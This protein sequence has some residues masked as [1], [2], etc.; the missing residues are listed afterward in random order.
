[1]ILFYN[2]CHHHSTAVQE[3]NGRMLANFEKNTA[4]T[5]V[6]AGEQLISEVLRKLVMTKQGEI[7]R[8]DRTIPTYEGV[9]TLA[10][11]NCLLHLSRYSGVSPRKTDGIAQTCT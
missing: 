3:I 2:I 7:T 6:K 5:S 8:M 10:S 1:M 4:D 11:L 9:G